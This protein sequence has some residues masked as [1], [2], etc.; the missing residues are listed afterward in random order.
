[1]MDALLRHAAMSGCREV[2]MGIAHRGRLNI[3]VNVLDKLYEWIFCEFEEH[4]D[5]Q[6]IYGGGT[7]STT[8]VSG[9]PRS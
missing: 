5:P 2:L 6:S 8:G 9:R 4:Y 3:Q 7:L 1:M